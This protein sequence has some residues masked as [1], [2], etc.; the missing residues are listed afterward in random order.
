MSNL[1]VVGVFAGIP[2]AIIA[3]IA[4]LT[5]LPDLARSPPRY[6]P[7]KEWEH[8]PV[9]WVA[10]QRVLDERSSPGRAETDGEPG[11]AR[12]TW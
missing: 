6:R 4:L 8:T 2:L 11:G 7:G 9:W 1:E 12:G 5:F 3:V 10:D